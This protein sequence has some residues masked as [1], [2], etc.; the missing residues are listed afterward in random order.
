[1][2][3]INEVLDE[4]YNEIKEENGKNLVIDEPVS[5][6]GWEWGSFFSG[7]EDLDEAYNE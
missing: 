2:T 1:L 3:L 5:G 6:G 4:A 7:S